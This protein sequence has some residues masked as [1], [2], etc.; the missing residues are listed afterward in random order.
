MIWVHPLSG[1]FLGVGE[2]F[3]QRP[4]RLLRWRTGPGKV[5]YCHAPGAIQQPE[6]HVVGTVPLADS[7]DW[8]TEERVPRRDLPGQHT[9]KCRGELRA[10]ISDRAP[11]LK[12]THVA[13]PP[14]PR[15]NFAPSGLSSL[16]RPCHQELHPWLSHPA[17]LGLLGYCLF[18]DGHFILA[19]FH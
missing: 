4:R 19:L 14:T 13:S 16:F 5:N 7:L 15:N 2:Q 8:D 17:P 12:P 11:R 10:E 18:A 3:G 9:L 1:E 6:K